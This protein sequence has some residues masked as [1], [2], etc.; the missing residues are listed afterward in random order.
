MPAKLRNDSVLTVVLAAD[1]AGL[2]PLQLQ[3][4]QN[5]AEAVAVSAVY[6]A[7]FHTDAAGRP[8]P[9]I[10]T[11]L[12][13]ADDGLTWTLTLRAGVRFSDGTALDAEA[14]RFNWARLGDPANRAAVAAT[15]GLIAE[16]R[17]LDALRLWIRL[18]APAARFDRRVARNLSSVGS[19]AMIQ[20]V[21]AG[22]ATAPVGAGPFRLVEW[23]R[24][25]RMR[26]VRNP[27]YWQP[28]KPHLDEV[29]VLTGI[30]EAA[31]KFALLASGRAQVSLEPMGPHLERYRAEPDRFALLGTPQAGGG[32]AL[33]LNLERAPFDDSRV[34]RAIALA[35]DSA[36]FVKEAGF[37]QQMVMTSLDRVG[38][39]FHD[40]A[41]RLPRRDVAQAQAM[42]DAYAANHGG[43]LG[44]T[45]ETFANEG[46]VREAEA[47]KRILQQRLRGVEV[48]VAASPVPELMRRW[49]AGAF[50]GS[51]FALG[52]ADPALDLPPVF[53][54]GSPQNIMRWRNPAVAAALERLGSAADERATVVAHQE[55][56]CQALADLPLV[57][58]SH[59]EAF[60]AVDRQAV[61][62][63]PLSYSLRPMIEEVRLAKP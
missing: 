28:G 34:R 46:H 22:F 62:A 30:S 31:A 9:K 3:G 52:W 56:L 1:P 14:V 7:L 5:W 36:T 63:W 58:L 55:V 20:A 11:G 16:M 32:V 15:A 12:V 49:S 35:V 13:T 33:A 8:Q 53:A 27:D 40:P 25:E 10:A 29:V 4:V 45:L 57:W 19:P 59:K 2:D 26:F 43:S 41:I 42:V 61:S 37:D 39:P 23:T 48:E 51:I 47:V 17:V 54:V 21:G 60:H 24:G 6:D 50:Q 38:S 18:K 44:F